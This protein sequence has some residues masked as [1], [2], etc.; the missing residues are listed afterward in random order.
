[1][2]RSAEPS[3]RLAR[4]SIAF[5]M[6]D[7]FGVVVTAAGI[8][9]LPF[10]LATRRAANLQERFGKL[11]RSVLALDQPIWIH[12]ASVGEV[13][14]A[15]PLVFEL[16]KRHPEI[17]LLVST[18]SLTGRA[19]ALDRLGADAVMLLPAD[20]AWIVDRTLRRVTPR[21]LIIIETEIWP[22]LLRAASRFGVPV[23][24]AS[25]CISSRS[26]RRYR[27][28]G[29][30]LRAVL[31][32]PRQFMMQ[33]AEDANRIIQLGAPPEHVS[34]VGSLKSAR[35]GSV[36]TE[37]DSHAVREAKLAGR[38]LVVAA[39][40][41]PGEEALVL[42]ACNTL[43][44]Q[45]PNLLLLLAPR[46]PLKGSEGTTFSNRHSSGNPW[47]LDP[48]RRTWRR[49]RQPCSRQVVHHWFIRPKN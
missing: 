22:A 47:R 1:M 5:A 23:I 20:I 29:S 25:G 28:A 13:L 43:R 26:A 7:L 2:T 34:V 15:E 12:A 8:M 41:H 3:T 18:T 4:A 33:T 39:S 46:R 6:Y 30:L 44:A 27:W 9:A 11:P 45:Y 17:P 48:I 38:L 37:G 36:A 19:T 49:P 42:D 32:L 14:A 10:L 31:A 35:R 21:C 40:T 16:R 24:F